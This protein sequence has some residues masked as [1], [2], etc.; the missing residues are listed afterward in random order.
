MKIEDLIIQRYTIKQQHRQLTNH[1][2]EL[3]LKIAE[4]K[5]NEEKAKQVS[6]E[7][8]TKEQEETEASREVQHTTGLDGDGDDNDSSTPSS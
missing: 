4:M 1:L 3:D 2:K 5:S 8:R 7:V 6:G